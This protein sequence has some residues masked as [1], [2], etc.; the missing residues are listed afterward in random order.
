MNLWIDLPSELVGRDT[1]LL[2]GRNYKGH[3]AYE[4]LMASHVDA[5]GY[6]MHLEVLSAY[7][8]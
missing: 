3:I 4:V 6:C 5:I 2:L 7:G 1:C 8:A